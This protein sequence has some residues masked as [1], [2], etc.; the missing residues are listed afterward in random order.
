ML[1]SR[2]IYYQNISMF[3]PLIILILLVFT[4]PITILVDGPIVQGLVAAVAAVSVAIAAVRIRPGEADFL[5]TVIR[6]A[7]VVAAVPAI[8]MLIQVMPLQSIGL[9]HPIWKSAASALGQPLA[10][11]IS[12]D[13]GATLVA[14]VRYL[15]AAAITF[16]AAAVAID[17]RRAEWVLFALTATATL[18]AMMLLAAKLGVFTFLSVGDGQAGIAATDSACLGVIF[19]TAAALHASDRSKTRQP[20]Q[21]SSAMWP[22]FAVYLTALVICSL[23]VI[24]TATAQAYFAVISGVAALAV[25]IVIRRFGIGPWGI[26]AIIS[27]TL[28]VAIAAVALQ[29]S[30]RTVDLTLAFAPQ[31]SM[32]LIAAT[33]GILAETGWAG[34]GAGTFAAVL[35]IY[36]DIDELASLHTAP[37]AAAAIAVELGRPILWAALIAAIVLVFTLL[38][39][40]LRRQRDSYY[41]IA[42]A[43]CIVALALLS[44][45]NSGLLSTPIS[46]LAAV[47]IGIAIAQSKSRLI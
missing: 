8:W 26:A 30:S 45:C 28:F 9:A 42:G 24:V 21:V 13:P 6:T 32:P 31:S 15:S 7:A 43:S 1:T 2:P 47:A 18:I 37:T 3:P 46:V 4:A 20:D 22:A 19:A 25:A 23:A 34:T 16:V 11:S 44:F 38:R 17:R 27:I 36:R 39:G 29:P 14:F 10:G 12:I 41:S 35:P 40:A 33:Q 5:S